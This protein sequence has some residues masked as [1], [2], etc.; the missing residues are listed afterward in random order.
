MIKKA[1]KVFIPDEM[2]V[3]WS[4]FYPD[5]RLRFRCNYQSD[6]RVAVFREG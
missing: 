1:R 3:T 5:E 2:K 4:W 6:L